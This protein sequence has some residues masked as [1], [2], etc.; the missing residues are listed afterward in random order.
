MS[1]IKEKNQK[2]SKKRKTEKK[3][4]NPIINK[5]REMKVN[6]NKRKGRE[7]KVCKKGLKKRSQKN[8]KLRRR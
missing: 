1:A 2:R 4:K 3:G 8:R 6:I 5:K 7:V